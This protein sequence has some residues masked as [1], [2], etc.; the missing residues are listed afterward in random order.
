MKRYRL[1][2]IKPVWKSPVPEQ[3]TIRASSDRRGFGVLAGGDLGIYRLAQGVLG[4][5]GVVEAVRTLEVGEVVLYALGPE[6]RLLVS[7]LGPELELDDETRGTFA[8][9]T[10]K[11]NVSAVAISASGM[12]LWAVVEKSKKPARLH[13]WDIAT[14][15]P[16]ADVEVL[17]LAGAVFDLVTHPDAKLERVG[18]DA[19]AGQDGSSFTFVDRNNGKLVVLP[20]S[21]DAED[22]IALG[23][24]VQDS[25]LLISREDATLVDVMTQDVLAGPADAT[26]PWM[27]EDMSFDYQRAYLD[28]F[29]A[30]SGSIDRDDDDRGELPTPEDEPQGRL[31]VFTPDLTEILEMPSTDDAYE[32]PWAVVG[33]V[34]QQ[35]LI[36]QSDNLMLYDLAALLG[37]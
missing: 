36:C 32:T 33:L 16:I 7:A 11:G 21:H 37:A 9:L 4:S 29:W 15:A 35:L 25:A 18:V 24:L 26:L 20:G 34:R 12:T 22:G 5:T 23:G 8:T 19:A 1:G 10:V 27:Q 3:P 6:A 30:L 13:A 28:G 2:A 31:R 14:L 17:A